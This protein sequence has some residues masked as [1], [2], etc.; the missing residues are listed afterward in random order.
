[1]PKNCEWCGQAF[2]DSKH[3]HKK[4]C[5]RQCAAESMKRRVT[6][7][8]L[9]CD[10][11]FEVK[12]GHVHKAIYCSTECRGV[13]QRNGV[14]RKC[15]HCGK[16]FLTA[17]AN[18]ERGKGKYCSTECQYAGI[19]KRV[20][21]ICPICNTP[22]QTLEY[23]AASGGGVFCSNKCFRIH[24][25]TSVELTCEICAEKYLRKKAVAQNSRFCSRSCQGVWKAK[26]N[27]QSTGIERAVAALLDSLKI[28]Y[29]AQHPLGRFL[30]DFYIPS[31]N[32][33]LEADG[34]YW[35]SLPTNQARDRRKN[36][37]LLNHG[38]RIIRLP[39]NKI[40]D[41][42]D[43]CKQQILNALK[44]EPWQSPLF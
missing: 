43:W 10:A 4:F 19:K 5:C 17:K 7:V 34:S 39:E 2:T 35:H 21:R 37:F 12:A 18:I 28:T 32:L 20:D 44:P 41:D 36:T 23:L 29:M 26:Q 42:L 3:P 6:R 27:Y 33:V 24:K 22:F 30:C 16:S 38:Y 11:S 25:N 1:M 15:E 14:T 13:A 40:N 8:C 9:V 31:A